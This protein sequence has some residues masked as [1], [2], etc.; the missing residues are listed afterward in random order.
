[1]AEYRRQIVEGG[2][3]AFILAVS[4]GLAVIY[5]PI[6][7][8]QAN[9]T[10]TSSI[11]TTGVTSTGPVTI[12]VT[13]ST[14]VTSPTTSVRTSPKATTSVTLT[15]YRNGTVTTVFGNGTTITVYSNGTETTVFQNQTQTV[16]QVSYDTY[17]QTVT[18]IATIIEFSGSSTTG[19]Q[20]P[21]FKGSGT[22]SYCIPIILSNTQGAPTQFDTQILL[23]VNWNAYA[24]DLASNVGNVL[25]A[26]STGTPLHA[27][28]ES[29]CAS[30]QISSNV[31]VKDDSSI[32]P[33]GQ[34]MIFMYIFPIITIQYNSGGS[35]GAY[36]TLT[37]T[38]G[39]FDN[40]PQ[41]FTF[42]NNFNGSSLCACMSIFGSPT[43][44]VNN[45]VTLSTTSCLGCGIQTNAV[46]LPN[47]TFDSLTQAT[48]GNYFMNIGPE[49][50]SIINQ[51]GI[52]ANYDASGYALLITQSGGNQHHTLSQNEP[53]GY[54]V[55]SD[56]WTP[57]EGFQQLNY[58][59]QL[60]TPTDIPSIALPW[61]ILVY[62][63]NSASITAQ[64][65]RVRVCP[66]NNMLPAVSFGSL[67]PY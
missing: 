16:T 7:G 1:L 10:A 33:S 30:N 59:S 26:D 3:A 17:V 52:F 35:W 11:Q 61:T 28:C 13:P 54:N 19:S 15:L 58:G 62:A 20:C 38:Y 45:G 50:T 46:Y 65:T 42:Y 51:N 47:V 34:Q 49:E 63:A 32:E 36:P 67:Y 56:S 21:S 8:L 43:I 9:T 44:T 5:V 12:H 2:V 27:W 25:F 37:S 60:T 4:I 31:W 24:S 53:S 22:P 23:N 18:S 48:M 40:G 55:W 39:Q 41:V 64:W 14:S 6:L 57:S 29:N 66:P